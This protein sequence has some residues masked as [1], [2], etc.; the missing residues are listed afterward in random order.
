VLDPGAD[1]QKQGQYMCKGKSNSQQ[2]HKFL[3][4]QEVADELGISERSVWRL[5]EEGE[6]LSHKFGA[7]TRVKREDLDAY[8]DRSRRHPDTTVQDG[9]D[10]EDESSGAP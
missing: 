6:L 8:I 5:I 4:I 9:A 7:S 2:V 3:T 1:D 10:D